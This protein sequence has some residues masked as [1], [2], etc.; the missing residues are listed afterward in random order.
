MQAPYPGMGNISR[1]KT[2]RSYGLIC[3]GVIVLH[4]VRSK[5]IGIIR[6]LR[7]TSPAMSVW[8]LTKFDT[9]NDTRPDARSR[10]DSDRLTGT[11]ER[12]YS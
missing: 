6:H 4:P 12:K 8:Y 3:L 1:V 7:L 11:Y 9:E 10:T 2:T 5:Y